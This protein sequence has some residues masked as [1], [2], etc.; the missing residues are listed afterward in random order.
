MKETPLTYEQIC[1]LED[2][3]DRGDNFYN[4]VKSVWLAMTDWPTGLNNTDDLI[5][6]LTGQVHNSLTKQNLEN[7][8]KELSKNF[9]LSGNGWK[10]ETVTSLLDLFTF[11]PD[12]KTLDEVFNLFI[13]TAKNK[14]NTADT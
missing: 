2:I 9:G 8:N 14:L 12:A 5:N 3:I 11:Y 10:A 6:A 7:Y 1:D 13:Q 4:Q